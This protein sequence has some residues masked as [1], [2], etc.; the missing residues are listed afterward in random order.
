MFKR[1][2]KSGLV[3]P[4]RI[5]PHWLEAVHSNDNTPGRHRAG[6][7]PSPRPVLA[8]HWVF[9][10]DSWLECRWRVESFDETSEQSDGRHITSK[11]SGLPLGRVF[12]LNPARLDCVVLHARHATVP[13]SLIFR[14]RSSNCE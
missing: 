4:R 8:C 12:S 13:F 2:A 1:L 3:K 14:V 11:I 6:R 7:R 5:A 9:I 10:D